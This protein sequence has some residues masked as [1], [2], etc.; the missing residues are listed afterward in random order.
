MSMK[1]KISDTIVILG[2]K[3]SGKTTLI[4]FLVETLM[5]NYKITILDVLGNF[6]YLCGKKNINYYLIN[7]NDT[8]QIEQIANKI[9]SEGNQLV[10]FDEFDTYPYNSM[11]KDAM[12]NLFQLGRNRNIGFLL[13]A[14]RT[15]N[16]SKDIIANA[17]HVFIG[18]TGYLPD[19]ERLQTYYTFDMKDY[20]SLKQYQFLYIYDGNAISKVMV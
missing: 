16:I 10:I 7:P 3:G 14:R 20:H 4:K 9:F 17:T 12:Y 8:K 5:K 2:K 13:S 18:A 6:S 1:I 15:A 11:H 19:I